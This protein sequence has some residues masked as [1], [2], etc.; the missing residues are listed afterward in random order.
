MACPDESAAMLVM[1]GVVSLAERRKCGCGEGGS[2]SVLPGG[3]SI[4]H[5]YL[6]VEAEPVQSALK[7]TAAGIIH[8]LLGGVK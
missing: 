1:K 3:L 2:N 4:H 6:N 5:H 8:M 7:G